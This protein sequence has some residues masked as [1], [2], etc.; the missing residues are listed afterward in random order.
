MIVDNKESCMMC[1][2][3]SVRVCVCVYV[4]VC[5]CVCVCVY[6]REEQPAPPSLFRAFPPRFIF[7]FFI[8]QGD[9]ALL[10]AFFVFWT[11]KESYI[12]AVGI[13]PLELFTFSCFAYELLM[14]SLSL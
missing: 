13:G 5:V 14:H 10:R 3:E 11:L 9:A 6:S 7:L 12:K 2:W 4:C 8:L 1:M